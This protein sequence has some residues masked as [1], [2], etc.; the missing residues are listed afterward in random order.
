MRIFLVAGSGQFTK[1][2]MPDIEKAILA[3]NIP[4]CADKREGNLDMKVF[5]AGGESRAEIQADERNILKPNILESFYNV[6]PITEKYIRCYN[7]YMLDS[8]AFTMLQGN[9][10]KVDLQSYIDKFI[11]YINKHKVK[12]YFELDIDPIA[13]YPEVKKIRNYLFEQTG[14][15]PIPVW[16]KSRGLAEF[17]KMCHDYSYVA[18]GGYVIKEFSRKE[19]EQFPKLI[20]Y[21]HR[22]G[23]KIHGLGFTSLKYLPLCHFDSV[24]STAWVSG[25]RFGHVYK[26][27]GKTM[28]KIDK[29]IGMRVKNKECAI[30][31][32]IEWVK[33]SKYAENHL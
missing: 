11:A 33:F 2:I 28:T 30:N 1:H 18:L 5:L 32:F 3:E 26:F 14:V 27:N 22:H 20:S 4:K 15:Q 21:A 13:G 19:I 16:H 10:G 29:P 9:A 8:G 17:K 6:S 25:N 23:A 24:D 31:N 7:D 12:K